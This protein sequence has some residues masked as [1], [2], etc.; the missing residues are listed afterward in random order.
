MTEDKE[1]RNRFA[2]AMGILSAAIGKPM[3]V[4]Q[5]NVYFSSLGDLPP[6]VLLLSVR[7]VLLEH[8]ITTI[9]TIAEI[10][11]IAAEIQHG[12]VPDAA[13]AFELARRA[14]S[15]F[16]FYRQD[17]GLQSLPPAIARIVTS[18]GW[19]AWC[20]TDCEDAVRAHFFRLWETTSVQAKRERLL[21]EDLRRQIAHVSGTAFVANLAKAL[22]V[23]HALEAGEASPSE[24][25]TL[26]VRRAELRTAELAAIARNDQIAARQAELREEQQH[27]ETHFGQTL[28]AMADEQF[29]AFR[30]D[31]ADANHSALHGLLLRSDRTGN[32][33]IYFLR[34][35]AESGERDA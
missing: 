24:V 13:E 12:P 19:Q 33:R 15:S 22:E 14:I 25:T 31:V 1:R 35:L 28:D 7:R 6:D 17:E 34:F 10:R 2:Q 29:H 16:G 11:K 21:P 23:P 27:L 26:A 8:T 30:R 20:D 18:I 4:E 5:A 3:N 9:P 32:G